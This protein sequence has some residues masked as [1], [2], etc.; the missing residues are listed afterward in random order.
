LD[1]LPREELLNP[2]KTVAD[3]AGCG[4][5]NF[6]IE[7][8]NRRIKAGIPHKDALRT[9]YGVDIMEDNIQECK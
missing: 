6:L 8:L 9:V 7:V 2:L 4:N 3:V 1:K 5:G